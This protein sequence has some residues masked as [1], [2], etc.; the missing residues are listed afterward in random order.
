MSWRELEEEL[1]R[2]R[3]AGRV[4]DF[5]WR[6][7]DASTLSTGLQRLL[8]LSARNAVPLALA[9][10]P[11]EAAPELFAGLGASVLMHGTD[12][13][14]RAAPGEKKTEFAAAEPEAEAIARL[15]AA[16]ERLARQAGASFLPVLAP[17]WNRF[18]RALAARLPAAGLHG[19]S[20][21]GPRAAAE[22]APGIRQVNTHVD[23]IDW[24]GTRGFAGEDA[25][26]RA[27]V[28]H[29][30]ARRS[31]AVDAAEPTGWL[32]HH[33][34]H[35]AAAQAFLERLF[36]RTRSL[37]ARWLDPVALFPSRT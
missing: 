33:A 13:R 14:N 12:H 1:G 27:A 10:V 21:Y 22:A 34:L 20:A 8:S 26:L 35:D 15:S 28:K 24:R 16:R 25:A 37:G 9:V 31:G 29:L 2:W 17:P 36:E 11:L 32:T 19:L 7:D 3:D 4:A 6:D 18:K 5:W 30:A 23:L